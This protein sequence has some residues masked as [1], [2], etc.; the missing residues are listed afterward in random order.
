MLILIVFGRLERSCAANRPYQCQCNVIIVIIFD[1]NIIM[2]K[3][4]TAYLPLSSFLCHLT[5]DSMA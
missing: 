3:C 4:S 5:L 2:E 1:I